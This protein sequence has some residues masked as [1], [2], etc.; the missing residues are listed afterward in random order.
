MGSG[1]STFS[2]IRDQN[3]GPKNRITE[4][5][6]YTLLWDWEDGYDKSPRIK[7][8]YVIKPFTSASN[9]TDSAAF[10]FACRAWN[11]KGNWTG[12]T[13]APPSM[14][15]SKSPLYG[16]KW[17]I[18]IASSYQCW[19]QMILRWY[20]VNSRKYLTFPCSILRTLFDSSSSSS[21][22]LQKKVLETRQ[23]KGY[24]LRGDQS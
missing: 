13:P 12:M 11:D 19:E 7:E 9:A 24:W 18:K 21:S 23:K 20:L 17:T 8:F 14:S 2:G 3:F 4:E 1:I 15:S 5:R 22:V 16:N 10:S 6:I